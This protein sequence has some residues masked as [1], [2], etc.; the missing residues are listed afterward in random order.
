MNTK[1]KILIVDDAELNRSVLADILDEKYE[2][3]EAENGLEAI[4]QIERNKRELS[5]VL[6]DIMM[7]EVDGFEVLAIMNK[8]KWL[9]QI[10]V[11]IIS[12][13]TSPAYIENAYDL[14][15]MEYISRPFEPRT[16]Q[17]RVSHMIMLYSKQKHLE[18]M[19][20][21]QM[22]E[23]EKSNQIM[24]DVLSHIVEF[25]NGESGMHVLNIRLVTELL[26]RRLC[27]VTDRYRDIQTKIPLIANASALHDIGKIS[28]DEKILN[29]PDRLTAEEYETMKFHSI[30]GA[31]MLEKTQYYPREELV[32]IARDICRW[33]H[34]RYDG[35]GYPDGLV[36]DEI[37]I[38]A[39]VVALA[40]VY[41][42]LT[43]ERVYKKAYSHEQ[44]MQMI[45]DGRCGVFNPLLL[46][47]LT[48]I[49]TDLEKELKICSL[50]KIP[51]MEAHDLAQSL[52][53]SGNAS[54]RTLALLEQERVKYQ[55]FAAMSREIQFEYSF[56][57]DM[58]VLSE[59]GAARLGLPEIT[60]YSAEK[61]A[62]QKMME[63][64][65][66]SNL[67]EQILSASHGE[68]TVIKSYRLNIRGQRRWH[69]ILARPLWSGEDL[70]EIIGI[71]GK[72]IDV[73]DELTE[74]NSLKQVASTD[75]LTGLYRREFARRKITETLAE[76][77]EA[78]KRFALILFDL[79]LF[80]NANDQYGHV[81]GDQVLRAVAHRL[82]KVVRNSDV[83]ARA[84]G[85]E[86][87]IFLE[88]K[89]DIDSAAKRIFTSLN[90]TYNG[91]D[92]TI[93]MG[94]ALAPTDATEYEKLFH[95]A[96]QALYTVKHKGRNGYCFYDK[97]MT[98]PFSALSPISNDNHS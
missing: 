46:R 64:D 85:D 72:C 36:G 24:V 45:M 56:Q 3:I 76:D 74:V 52:L 14:G 62:L 5:L 79:D 81:F 1:S 90:G 44:S 2:I 50:G 6:L 70:D 61:H 37:P 97:S 7:P 86:F 25:R 19:V 11:I 10:P 40:D 82:Q 68:P 22:L 80:K 59:W 20:T 39:Q 23:K 54:N 12:S 21:E 29:K 32:K 77:T 96:D 78:E 30:A 65:D 17:H 87:M 58:L 53:Q 51:K 63:A 42:A 9:E 26:L 60:I 57:T 4:A 41:D 48:D 91:F 93:S 88:Y 73:H 28:I 89:A 84:G 8:N 94:I 35:G 31:N 15:A 38:E 67:R 98:S 34:E 95:Y 27:A 49:G 18:N 69:K 83:V 55:F 71:I 16:V 75:E 66:Y 33:H 13:E 47:C 43:H 92:T